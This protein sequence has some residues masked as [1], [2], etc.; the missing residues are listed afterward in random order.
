MSEEITVF[1]EAFPVGKLLIDNDGA[2]S[3]A[4]DLRWTKSRGAF[5][6]SLT[7]P[8]SADTYSPDTVHPWLANLLPEERQL[9]TLARAIGVDR[10][11]TIAILREIGG[12]TA[13]ALSFGAPSLREDWRY[14]PLETFYQLEDSEAALL[15]HFADLKERPFLAGEDGVRLSLA[16]G[17]E[18]ATLTVVDAGGR[19]RLGL[20]EPGDILAIPKTGAPSTLIVKPDNDRIPGI[21]ENEAYCLTLAAA[22][23]IP[24]AE[25]SI[26]KAGPRNALAVARYDRAYRQD[27][28]IRR[29]HQEDFAQ[30]NRVFPVNKYEAGTVPGP[31][32]ATLLATGR[33]LPSRDGLKLLDQLIFNILV[34]NTDAHA[35][36]YSLLLA[37]ER[38]LAPLYDVS[39]VLPWPHVNQNFAQKIDGKKRKP[40]DVAA[41]H[42]DA[43]AVAGGYN[44][45]QTRLRVKELVDA[46]VGAGVRTY[47]HVASHPGAIAPLVEQART[48]VEGNALRILGRLKE[49]P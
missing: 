6:I 28:Q 47:E 36:N 33:S 4:Y 45:R 26:L 14:E 8:F 34:A 1:Y 31:T 3:F 35:K 9:T 12:D 21:V 20:P 24:T 11:D 16:G 19:P 48:C 25:V 5:P 27:G 13:G 22:I 40:E 38:A 44:P 18:K 15:R 39:T 46:I 17:Q 2:I 10:T 7:M 41:R 29:L 37:G 23:G 42:W 32:I 30:A 49:Y 43:I